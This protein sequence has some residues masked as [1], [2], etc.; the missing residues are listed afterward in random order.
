MVTT[1][2]VRQASEP[3]LREWVYEVAELP[4]AVDP[5]RGVITF[6]IDGLRAAL[7][8]TKVR[9]RRHTG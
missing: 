7:A 4:A 8:Y 5:E 3:G 2:A 9:F 6:T 1:L